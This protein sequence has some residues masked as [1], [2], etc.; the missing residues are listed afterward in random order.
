MKTIKL[1]ILGA[2]A[3]FSIMG[4]VCVQAIKNQHSNCPCITNKNDTLYVV[5]AQELLFRIN[6]E[7]GSSG[8][9]TMSEKER[10]EYYHSL[11]GH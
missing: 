5:D 11:N 7:N 4:W 1:F 6:E 3:V 8:T 9:D 2:V 10:I